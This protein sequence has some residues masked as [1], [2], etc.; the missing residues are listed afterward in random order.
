MTRDQVRELER[1]AY[2]FGDDLTQSLCALILELMSKLEE[3]DNEE[4]E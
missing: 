4:Y 1:N 2:M 3:Q